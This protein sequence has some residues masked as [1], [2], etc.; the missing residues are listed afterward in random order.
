MKFCGNCGKQ[1]DDNANACPFC[2]TMQG[3]ARPQTG[4]QGGGFP[5]A[6]QF[7]GF[8]A[9]GAKSEGLTLPKILMLAGGVLAFL[10]CFFSVIKVSMSA[11]GESYSEGISMLGIGFMGV[12]ALLLAI[13]VIALV[14]VDTF[15]KPLGMIPLIVAAVD[16]VWFVIMFIY[17]LVQKGRANSMLGLDDLGSLGGSIGAGAGM[18]FGFW[19]Y[20]IAS[21]VIAAG[22]VLCFLGKKK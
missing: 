6:G 8:Q 7:A 17:L 20:L 3:G 2:G 4:R 21:L 5:G 14:V 10:S 19:L 13:A 18:G 16:V 22:T 1:I 9:G 15:V 11:F 12:L